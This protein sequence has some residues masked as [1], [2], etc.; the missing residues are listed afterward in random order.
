LQLQ[1]THGNHYV[2][3]LVQRH[4]ATQRTATRAEQAPDGK[5][6]SDGDRGTNSLATRIEVA[7]RSGAPLAPEVRAQLEPAVGGDLS[8]VRVHTDS[9]ADR[10]AQVVDAVAFTTGP[11]VFFRAGAYS[12]SGSNV[13]DVTVPTR[14]GNA[15]M[16]DK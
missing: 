10:L 4:L 16:R 1:Q 12:P 15:H 11:N 14:C 7:S 9:E 6:G 3:R 8:G 2:Q 5:A 13:T